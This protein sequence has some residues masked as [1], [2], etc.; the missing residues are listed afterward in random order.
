MEHGMSAKGWEKQLTGLPDFA[1]TK[2]LLEL[3]SLRPHN[4]FNNKSI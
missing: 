3:S 4:L 1:V 2:L